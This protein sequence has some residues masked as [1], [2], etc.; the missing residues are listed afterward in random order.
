M[1]SCACCGSTVFFGKGSGAEKYCNDN[2]VAR[3]PIYN[4]AKTVPDYLVQVEA[5]KIF[6]S[7]CPV[8]RNPG[9]TDV[10]SSHKI[11]SA[12]IMTSW[13]SRAQFSCK[14]CGLKSQ[15]LA[16]VQSLLLGWWG[17]PWGILGTPVTIGRN[18]YGM[19]TKIGADRPSAALLNQTR[20]LLA[21][22]SIQQARQ[23]DGV[24]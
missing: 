23:S 15:A 14:P 9:P 21:A 5:E 16:A 22:Q 7:P 1:A 24:R 18:V 10:H 3:G 20:S 17:I 11:W 6:K 4:V 2:C 19:A 12:L 13:N 8:C